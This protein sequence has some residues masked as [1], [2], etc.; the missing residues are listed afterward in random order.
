MV[1]NP[2]RAIAPSQDNRDRPVAPSPWPRPRRPCPRRFC[3]TLEDVRHSPPSRRRPVIEVEVHQQLR[4]FLRAAQSERSWA[5]HLTMARL[6]ARAMRLQR[7]AILQT[8]TAMG[9]D[10]HRLSYLAPALLWPEPVVIVAPEAVQ[11]RL[12]QVEIPKLQTWLQ[13]L[14]HWQPKPIHLW[15]DDPNVSGFGGADRAIASLQTPHGLLLISPQRWLQDA[16]SPVRRLAGLATV[17]DGADDLEQWCRDWLTETLTPRDWDELML[18]RPDAANPIRDR[19]V[20]LTHSLFQRPANPYHCCAL[21]PGDRQIL[22]DLIHDLGETGPL[23]G[24]WRAFAPTLTRDGWTPMAETDRRTGLFRLTASPVTVADRLAPLWPQQPVVL[25]GPVLDPDPEAATFRERIGFDDGDFGEADRDRDRA[26]CLKFLPDRHSDSLQLYLPEHLPFPNTPHFQ[27]AL[28]QQI[29]ALL[30]LY[31]NHPT[32]G[33]FTV[34]LVGDV[35][36]KAQVGSHLAAEFGRRVRVEETCPDDHGILVAGWEFWRDRQQHLPV[37]TLL[38]ITAL[39]IPSL[40]DPRVAARV[41]NYKRHRR[42]W[43]RLYLL[44]TALSELQRAVAPMRA[45]DRD[46]PSDR[47]SLIALLDTR[48]VRRSYGQQVLGALSPIARTSYLDPHWLFPPSG[49]GGNP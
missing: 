42:D 43:F 7:S 20:A 6:V 34:I 9:C 30:G 37:P 16:F 3:A 23:P 2:S 49:A 4:A 25:I 15:P 19:R 48:V 22:L 36:L 11:Q 1:P 18:A 27:R 38:I 26:T 33:G 17:M 8:G 47:R 12:R 29:H 46:S 24:P 21:D 35:P 39:P 13:T 32:S 40:E 31:G 5:H 28:L 10:R 45:G 14:P 41:E 44:P